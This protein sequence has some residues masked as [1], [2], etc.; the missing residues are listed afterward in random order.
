MSQRHRPP[1]PA[2]ALALAAC[3]LLLA[4][5]EAIYDD[6]KGWANRLEASIL[7]AA[8][9]LSEDPEVEEAARY[10]PE[11]AENAPGEAT[12][13]LTPVPR[14]D[15]GTPIL[16]EPNPAEDLR[17]DDLLL[18][19]LP[20]PTEPEPAKEAKDESAPTEPE[21][22]AV[23]EKAMAAA[24]KDSA[25]PLPPHPKRKPQTATQPKPGNDVAMVLHLSS[26]RSEQAAKREWSDLQ[27]SFPEPLGK[28]EAEIR[29]TELG[30]KGVYYRVLAGPLPSDSAAKDVCAALKSKDAKQYCRVMPSK[31][32]S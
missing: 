30:D 2:S 9:D 7:E 14:P 24:A 27:R 6:T 10:T 13:A 15:G 32:K 26:L 5:C 1:A 17:Q 3:L 16:I 11:T 29:R 25:A 12:A 22:A 23:E 8:N 21:K 19:E 18:D 28:M 20:D 31:P 4:G